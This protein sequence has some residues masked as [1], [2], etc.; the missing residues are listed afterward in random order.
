MKFVGL[1]YAFSYLRLVF[2]LLEFSVVL[3]VWACGFLLVNGPEICFLS[4]SSIRQK[5]K[6]VTVLAW[7]GVCGYFFSFGNLFHL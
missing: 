4:T 6:R 5:G 1:C 3:F 2:L 7:F